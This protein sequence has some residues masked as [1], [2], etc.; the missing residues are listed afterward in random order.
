MRWLTRRQK[1]GESRPSA[2][3]PTA[4]EWQQWRHHL[5]AEAVGVIHAGFHTRQECRLQLRDEL[6]AL[7]QDA[8]RRLGVAELETIA[9]EVT[10]EVWAERAAQLAQVDPGVERAE[11]V[12]L[13]AAFQRLREQG[14]LTGMAFGCCQ[15]CGHRDMLEAREESAAE[16]GPGATLPSAHSYVFFHDQDSAALSRQ[17]PVLRLAFS[18]FPDHPQVDPELYSRAWAGEDAAVEPARRA[19]ARLE[20]E[21]GEAIVAALRAEELEVEWD[22][23]H[24]HRPVVR[25]REWSKP[26][27]D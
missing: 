10:D 14:F 26:L 4:Q 17:P 18:Y 24:T 23:A 3:A 8:G 15:E 6:E 5:H 25:L 16:T 27:P 2:A 21:V 19:H 22:G 9:A 1:R 11:H 12:R 20:T 13:E 7:A